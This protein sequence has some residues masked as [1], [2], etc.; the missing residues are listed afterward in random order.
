[1]IGL[2]DALMTLPPGQ[3]ADLTGLD[4]LLAACWDQFAGSNEG[5]MAAHKLLHRME[6]VYWTPPVLTFIVE[7]HGATDCGSTRA[8]LQHWAVDFDAKTAT[9]TKVGHR[10]L[11]PMAPRLSIKAIAEDIAQ[12]IFDG[13][14]D[15]RV[16]WVDDNTV[17]V[18]ASSIFP[19]GSGFKMT[20]EGR[21]KRLLD[22]IEKAVGGRAWARSD[23]STFKRKEAHP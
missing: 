21:R 19:T 10:Q 15:D 16:Y 14:E 8:E 6:D 5:G 3:V 9:I 13:K 22:H 1:M 20:A 2:Q 18:Q 4:G 7:R 11:E 17:K 12:A 23:K